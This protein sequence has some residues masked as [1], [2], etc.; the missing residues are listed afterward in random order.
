MSGVQEVLR[1]R[2]AAALPLVCLLAVG[3][4]PDARAITIS[5]LDYSTQGV[6]NDANVY[7]GTYNGTTPVGATWSSDPLVVPPPGNWSGIYQSPFNNTPLLNTQSYF[8][9]GGVDSSGDGATSPVTLTYSSLQNAFSMLWGSI[10]SYNTLEFRQGSTLRYSLSGQT[11]GTLLGG[12]PPNYEQVALLSFKFNAN[13]LFNK[14]RFI[15]TQAAFE[16]ALPGAPR[17]VPE[18]GTLGLLALGLLGLGLLRR[19]S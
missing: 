15:S 10:D 1:S 16:F 2:F 8:S 5:V 3:V 9:V 12:A 17:A 18:P 6:G 19:R 11:L 13:E 14:V 4:T 7:A